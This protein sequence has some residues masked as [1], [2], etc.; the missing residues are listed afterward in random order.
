M[1]INDNRRTLATCQTLDLEEEERVTS[2]MNLFPSKN[3]QK[4]LKVFEG[5]RSPIPLLGV[6]VLPLT[7][8]GRIINILCPF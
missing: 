6:L 3:T 5:E 4:T 1:P 2:L 8:S 7:L